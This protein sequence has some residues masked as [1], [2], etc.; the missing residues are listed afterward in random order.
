RTVPTL[1]QYQV[2]MFS[3]SASW[4]VGNGEWLTYEGEKS[5]QDVKTRILKVKPVGDTNLYAAFELAFSLRSKG[6]DTIYL[7][8]DRLPARGA[9]ST[10]HPCCSRRRPGMVRAIFRSRSA[11]TSRSSF[12]SPTVNS[13]FTSSASSATCSATRTPFAVSWISTD[14]R[15]VGLGTRTSR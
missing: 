9:Y 3:R 14:R 15:S 2:V 4:L 12:P 11:K 10:G 6:L 7:F 8:A 5:A 13:R 1:E